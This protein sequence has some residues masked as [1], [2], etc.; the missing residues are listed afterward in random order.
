MGGLKMK[1]AIMWL[2]AAVTCLHLSAAPAAAEMSHDEKVAA[3]AALLGLAAVLHNKHH[4]RGGYEPASGS[5]AADFETC[6]RDGLHGYDYTESS[7]D[8]AEGWQAGN[9]ERENS[10]AHRRTAASDRAPPMAIRG[11]T[12]LVATN[13]DVSSHHVHIIK[14]RSPGKH[15]WEIEA[16]VGHEHMVCT[17][18][19]SGEVISARGGRL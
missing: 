4:Y 19:D 9:A 11:C 13:F 5:H 2:G 16:A 8:C 15:E 18:R 6:Y 17:M 12:D 3:A 7:R 1:H 14:S 10:V